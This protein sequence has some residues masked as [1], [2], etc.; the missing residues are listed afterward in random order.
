MNGRTIAG[1][2]A[3]AMVTLI[4]AV[5]L[6]GERRDSG[7]SGAVLAQVPGQDPRLPPPRPAT[8]AV[9]PA[10]PLS[11]EMLKQADADERVNIR[12]YATVN[13]GVVNI[14]TTTEAQSFFGDEVSSGTGSGFVLDAQGHILTNFHVVQGADSLQ[15]TL[16]DGSNHDAEVVGLDPSNDVAVIRIRVPAE[17]LT[18]VPLGDS[19]RLLVGQKVLALGN[20]FGL[21]RTL[22]TGIVSSLD[23]SLRAKNGRMIKGIIQTDAAINP[24][25]SGGPLLNSR[26]EVIGMNT[27][28]YSQVGQSAGIGF[29]VPINSIERILKPLIEQGR[30]IRADLGVLRVLKTEA[31]LLILDLAEDGPAERA[32]LRPIQVRVERYG[33]FVRRRLDPDSADVIVAINGT[34]VQ[35]VDELLTEV[36][37]HPPG[38]AAKVTVL[39][40]LGESPE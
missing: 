34:P 20:P 4:L 3:T 17:K 30:V 35:N 10:P 24:G 37:A 2:V 8:P 22:T 26:G 12:V 39:V 21:E 5:A 38:E 11:A 1:H 32:G 33:R 16:F 18:P 29:A 25:N 15:V 23:R 7:R 9:P 19:S 13:H 14:T 40:T 28:I 31:G 27:A 6:L 36:E